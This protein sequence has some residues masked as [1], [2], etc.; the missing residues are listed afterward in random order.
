M[1]KLQSM[2]LLHKNNGIK[3]VILSIIAACFC[4]CILLTQRMSEEKKN[5]SVHLFRFVPAQFDLFVYAKELS[6]I[7]ATANFEERYKTI[8]NMLSHQSRPSPSLIVCRKGDY[9]ICQKVAQRQKDLLTSNFF[10][11]MFPGFPPKTLRIE[12][13]DYYFYSASDSSFWVNT[14]V[15]GTFLGSYNF[16]FLRTIVAGYK[17]G[18]VFWGTA[19]SRA[20]VEEYYEKGNAVF[21]SKEKT[22]LT[23][24]TSRRMGETTLISGSKEGKTPVSPGRKLFVDFTLFP[25]SLQ[26]F[27]CTNR[28]NYPLET[29]LLNAT[30]GTEY[31]YMYSTSSGSDEIRVIPLKQGIELMDSIKKHVCAETKII[32]RPF[33]S[34]LG[35]YYLHGGGLLSKEQNGKSS[36]THFWTQWNHYLIISSN[37]EAIVRYVRRKET[38]K[39]KMNYSF[40]TK[41]GKDN[42]S[43]LYYSENVSLQDFNLFPA[44]MKRLWS[45]EKKKLIYIYSD[46]EHLRAFC[47]SL[48]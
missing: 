20:K 38:G 7:T 9:V 41:Y 24:A 36:P 40:L 48:F 37:A 23:I 10:P 21:I 4:V 26:A 35:Q 14:V 31:S 1:S 29:R 22:C 44:E 11:K 28:I 19:T 33:L 47:S 39:D 42:F 18:K 16:E 25:D 3:V 8:F 34:F 46:D 5:L 43:E 17:Q 13:N 15:D 6:L 30:L 45:I 32:G 2:N 12:G 27:K